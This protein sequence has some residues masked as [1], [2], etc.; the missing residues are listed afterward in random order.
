MGPNSFP[1]IAGIFL[2]GEVCDGQSVELMGSMP[3][4]DEHASF[5]NTTRGRP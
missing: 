3:F 4:D 5:F 2:L 1:T